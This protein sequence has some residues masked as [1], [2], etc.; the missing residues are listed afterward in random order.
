MCNTI[1]LHRL[2]L[3]M[4]HR[5]FKRIAVP[6]MMREGLPLHPKAL[7]YDHS[8]NTLVVEVDTF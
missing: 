2:T 8:N 6:T 5:Y 7:S 4:L 1:L 3:A